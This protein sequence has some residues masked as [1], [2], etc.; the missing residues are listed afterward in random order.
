MEQKL[1]AAGEIY[2]QLW[3]KT[4]PLLKSGELR[5]DPFLRNKAEDKRRGVTLIARPDIGV[6]R[7]VEEFLRQIAGICPRQHYYRPAELHVTVMAIISGSETWQDEMDQLPVCRAA[8]DDVLK[9]A[10]PFR[11][12]FRGVTVS[13]D[14]VMIQ[15]FPLGNGLSGIRDNLRDTFKRAGLGKNLD[16]RYK[17]TAAHLTVMRFS[18]PKTSWARLYDFLEMHRDA[19]F[20]QTR[21]CSLQLIWSDWYASADIVRVLEE[22]PLQLT[23]AS[24]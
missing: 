12:D 11:V 15:G 18:E 24:G 23:V 1:T 19:D 14:A 5:V 4:G 17:T 20:G 3:K 16:R 8:L 6:Q 21:F 10:R 9:D 7:R 22:Y 2:E 13:S